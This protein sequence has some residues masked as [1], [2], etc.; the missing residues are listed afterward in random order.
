MNPQQQPQGR[1]AV[2]RQTNKTALKK[3]AKPIWAHS[4]EE[5]IKIAD[6]EAIQ[7]VSTGE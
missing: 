6:M 3:I 2:H 1:T 4:L 7:R 5:A